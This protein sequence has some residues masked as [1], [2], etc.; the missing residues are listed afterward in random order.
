MIERLG[1]RRVRVLTV[2]ETLAV[3]AALALLYWLDVQLAARAGAH[4]GAFLGALFTAIGLAFG[5]LADKAVSIAVVMFHVAV[6]VGKAL[7]ETAIAIARVFREVYGFLKKFWSGVL[8]PFITWVWR[9]VERLARFLRKVTEPILKFLHRVRREILKLYERFLRPVLDTIDVIRQT[10]R[11]LAFLRLEWAKE[12][13]RKLAELEDRLLLPLRF[14]L[15]K[16]NEVINIVNSVASGFGVLQRVALI[17]SMWRYQRDALA[18]WWH[19]IHRPLEGERR[20]EYLQP[21]ETRSLASMASDYRAYVVDRSGPDAARIDEH[22][23][24]YELRIR[25]LSRLT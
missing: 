25:A 20:N 9:E 3:W 18:V 6:Y 7:W 17:G 16:I 12:L 22:A 1:I 13:D 19:S 14:A 15:G 23:R 24:D 8:R 11:L 2:W 21:L 4:T 5:W 10:L